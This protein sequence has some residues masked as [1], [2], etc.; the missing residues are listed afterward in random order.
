MAPSSEIIELRSELRSELCSQ[1]AHLEEPDWDPTAPGCSSWAMVA[2]GKRKLSLP[3][4]DPNGEDNSLQLFNHSAL[5]AEDDPSD[6]PKFPSPHVLMFR[7][8]N[9]PQHHPRNVIRQA[10]Q[11][12]NPKTVLQMVLQ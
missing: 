3:L 9:K 5:L 4:Y 7:K 11:N 12:P 8:P 1:L 10:S 6:D 2:K